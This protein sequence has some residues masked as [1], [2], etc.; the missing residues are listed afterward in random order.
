LKSVDKWKIRWGLISGHLSHANPS[1]RN[2]H[3]A[4]KR[5]NPEWDINK[6]YYELIDDIEK[7]SNK[8][9]FKY[10]HRDLLAIILK[11]AREC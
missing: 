2:D 11:N 3:R 10:A 5:E 4:S 7:V 8:H 9:N 6:Y 1:N